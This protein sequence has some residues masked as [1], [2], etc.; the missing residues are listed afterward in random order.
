MSACD[1]AVAWS[2]AGKPLCVC[3]HR[4]GA[5]ALYEDGRHKWCAEVGCNCKAYHSQAE[6]ER[7]VQEDGA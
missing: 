4:I 3:G 2:G 1:E 6:A 7:A 5:H